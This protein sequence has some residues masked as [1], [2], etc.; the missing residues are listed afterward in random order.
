M[1]SALRYSAGMPKP[2]RVFI[3][4][5]TKNVPAKVA[6]AIHG[7]LAITHVNDPTLWPAASQCHLYVTTAALTEAVWRASH[8]MSPVPPVVLPEATDW[9]REKIIDLTS[10]G[11]VFLFVAARAGDRL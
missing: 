2:G 1:T 5:R 8:A 6:E 9:L 3:F 10:R 11:D 7:G 4:S